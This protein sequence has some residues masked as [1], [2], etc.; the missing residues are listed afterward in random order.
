MPCPPQILAGLVDLPH[1]NPF[2]HRV[3]NFLRAGFAS[4]PDFRAARSLQRRY[5]ISRHQIAARLH[6][7]RNPR[8]EIFHGIRELRNPLRRKRENIVGEPDPVRRER[9]LQCSISAAT[10]R[11]ERECQVLAVDRLRA[12]VAPV[13]A[14]AARRHIQ[15]KNSRVSAS[16]PAGI[17]RC[18]PVPTRAMEAYPGRR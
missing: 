13:R 4:H 15:L 10:D 3:E 8:V 12:P 7:E 5:R 18:R 17:G 9:G 1:A 6:L 11:A 2:L 14:A 16:T